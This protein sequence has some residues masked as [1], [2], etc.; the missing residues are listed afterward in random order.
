LTLLDTQIGAP[1]G[2]FLPHRRRGARSARCVELA[3]QLDHLEVDGGDPGA[4]AGLPEA[5][6]RLATLNEIG[7]R[8]QQA[9][10]LRVDGA[11]RRHVATRECGDEG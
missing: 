3:G 6:D 4:A 2:G 10:A 8:R 9:R 5:L 11:R 1:L 7:R